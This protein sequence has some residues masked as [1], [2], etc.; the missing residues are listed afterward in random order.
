M[1][2]YM[3]KLLKTKITINIRRFL[4]YLISVIY[5][6]TYQ[7]VIIMIHIRKKNYKTKP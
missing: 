7:K 2:C 6:S 5:I 3:L 4:K 1:I